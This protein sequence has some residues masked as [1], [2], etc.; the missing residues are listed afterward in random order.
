MKEYNPQTL[1]ASSFNS[2]RSE[3]PADRMTMVKST[4]TGS[5][6]HAAPRR[7]RWGTPS[8]CTFSVDGHSRGT[9]YPRLLRGGSL[10]RP[11]MNR[12]IE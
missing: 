4:P 1:K 12:G 10:Q 7:R 2:R 5:P 11:G 3:R 9:S 6:I 8:G